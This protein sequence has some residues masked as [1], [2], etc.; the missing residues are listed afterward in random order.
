MPLCPAV[1]Y[2]TVFSA[3]GTA[4]SARYRT[5][6]GKGGVRIGTGSAPQLKDSRPALRLPD[7]PEG[8]D[9]DEYREPV[10]ESRMRDIVLV[11]R[12]QSGERT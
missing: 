2:R 7:V 6:K 9:E 8:S 4:I 10:R 5:E 12:L 1:P 3:N 11:D